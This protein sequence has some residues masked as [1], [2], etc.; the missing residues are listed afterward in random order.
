MLDGMEIGILG[1][2]VLALQ[3]AEQKKLTRLKSAGEGSAV[4]TLF[5]F[6]RPLLLSTAIEII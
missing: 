3:T 6:L 2:I 1:A 5:L 4:W